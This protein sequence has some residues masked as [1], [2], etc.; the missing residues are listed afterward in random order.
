[1][2]V[3]FGICYRCLLILFK[4]SLQSLQN[5]YKVKRASSC[6]LIIQRLVLVAQFAVRSSSR[7]KVH[8]K[9]LSIDGAVNW[10]MKC[11]IKE[12]SFTGLAAFAPFVHWFSRNRI[13]ECKHGFHVRELEKKPSGC[14]GG[15]AISALVPWTNGTLGCVC[16]GFMEDCWGHSWH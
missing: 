1:M 4:L 5:V 8:R 9:C 6:F 7:V 15:F 10:T 16:D 2:R 13:W 11:Q 14:G 3:A 12:F